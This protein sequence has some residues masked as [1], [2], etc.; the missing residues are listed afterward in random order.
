MFS[1]GR[2]KPLQP[3]HEVGLRRLNAESAL[4]AG[5]GNEL[6]LFGKRKVGL[7]RLNA[8]S[9]QAD[10]QIS[11]R[12]TL[13]PVWGWGLCWKEGQGFVLPPQN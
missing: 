7:R 4:R 11:P 6:P 12:R 1:V 10:F 3:G 13:V 8:E 9:A 2:L 5:A